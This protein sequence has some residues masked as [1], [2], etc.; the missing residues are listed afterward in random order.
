MLSEKSL[1]AFIVLSE[2]H[3]L[4]V[5]VCAYEEFYNES[6]FTINTENSLALPCPVSVLFCSLSTMREENRHENPQLYE[7][8]IYIDRER[9]EI[10]FN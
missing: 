2:H 7:L 4:C 3:T 6:S 10:S 5:C 9:E 8:K 1:I